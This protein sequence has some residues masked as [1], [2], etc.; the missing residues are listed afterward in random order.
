MRMPQHVS[1]HGSRACQFGPGELLCCEI[2][3][4]RAPALL[5]HWKWD[6]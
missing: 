3:A 5:Q 2:G 4:G 6:V 1:W